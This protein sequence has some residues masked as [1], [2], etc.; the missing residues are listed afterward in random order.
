LRLL[1]AAGANPNELNQ[2]G[3]TALHWAVWRGRSATTVGILLDAGT[4][5]NARRKDGRTA[6]ALAVRSGQSETAALLESR[7]ADTEMAALDRFLGTCA[8]ADPADLPHVLA[9]A[10]EIP[11]PAEYGRL[12]PELASSHCTPAVRALLAAGVPINTP[13]DFAG[14]ALHWACL[15]GYA[16]LVEVLIK[17]GASLTI[18]DDTYHSTPAGWL[19]H[20]ITN[21]PEPDGNY[22]EVERLL[23]AAGVVLE[24]RP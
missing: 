6:Y 13:G 1:L 7:G 22:A 14:T 16:D 2:R 3:E 23:L 20:G 11:L 8:A 15:N 4:D 10:P 17:H 12:L 5:V 21:G 24:T 19:L 18:E 9:D